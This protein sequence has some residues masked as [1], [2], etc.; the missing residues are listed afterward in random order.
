MYT[1]VA[2]QQPIAISGS[3]A[4][5]QAGIAIGK[6]LCIATYIAICIGSYSVTVYSYIPHL[7]SP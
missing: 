4:I 2:T 3:V 6:T 7:W 5:I 1:C